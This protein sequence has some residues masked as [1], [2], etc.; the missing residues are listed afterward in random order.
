M[1]TFNSST[2][3]GTRRL[4]SLLQQYKQKPKIKDNSLFP[5]TNTFK[6]NMEKLSFNTKLN[7]T[8]NNSVQSNAY[9][10]IVKPVIVKHIK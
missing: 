5:Q 8:F 10:K 1:I 9:R 2:P 7:S 4:A 3:I 6:K